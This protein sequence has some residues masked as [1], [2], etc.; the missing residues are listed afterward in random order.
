MGHITE[1]KSPIAGKAI[2]DTFAGPNRAALRES[3]APMQV[4]IK[5]CRLSKIF[6]SPIPTKQPAVNSPQNHETAVAP[7]VCGS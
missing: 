3:S 6:N 7:V 5:T 2:T 4:P 1:A